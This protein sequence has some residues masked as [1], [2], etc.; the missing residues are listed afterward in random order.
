MPGEYRDGARVLIMGQAPGAEEEAQGRPFVGPTGEMMN[1]YLHRAGL[2]RDDCSFDNAIRCRWRGSNNLPPVGETVIRDAID[3]CA[4]AH[5]RIPRG[6]ELVVTQGDYACLA[7]TGDG[8]STTWRGW[9]VPHVNGA[10][11]GHHL[12]EP[13]VP[14]P[15][16]LAVLP[17]VHLARL[18]HEPA[19]GPATRMDW[20]KIPRILTGTWPRRPPRFRYEPVTWPQRF[21][22]DTEYVPPVYGASPLSAKLLRWSLSW[23]LEDGETTVVEAGEAP[24]PWVNPLP[25]ATVITQYA[26]ADVHHL[27]RL[28]GLTRDN[29]YRTVKLEDTV[30]KHSVLYPD[31][32]HNL[33]FLGSLFSSMNRWKHLREVPGAE[34]LYAGCDALG[35][36]EVDNALERELNGDPRSRWLYENVDRPAIEDF[37]EAQY[38]GIWVDHRRAGEL[39]R[40]L[41]LEAS[42]AGAW[43]T[44]AVGWPINLASADQVGHLLYNYFGMPKPRRKRR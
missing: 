10:G 22:F 7:A 5:G 6:T 16:S 4:R 21:A 26:P 33:D 23:G 27:A 14:V 15:G 41:A 35:T 18:F 17:T 13:W 11:H 29:L 44:A 37:V 19:L 42:E 1:S 12:Q 8:S 40:E 3:H 38:R 31:M 28:V 43:A 24:E 9:L 2:T 36:L 30:I 39:V 25:P 34:L 20:A 32:E